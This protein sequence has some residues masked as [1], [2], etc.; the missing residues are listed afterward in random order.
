MQITINDM[1]ITYDIRG[2]GDPVLL[3]HGWGA[4]IDAMLPIANCIVSCGMQA[5]TLDFPGFGKS[6]PPPVPWG[7]REYADFVKEFIRA[8]NL[9]TVDVVC[10]SFGG[11]VTILLAGE[12]PALFRRLV[13]VDAAG[14]R[15]KRSLKYYI[16]TYTYKIGK[17][18]G[19]IKF[20]DRLFHI[21][22]KQKKAGSEEYRALSGV[23]RSTFVKVVNLDLTDK[24]AKI[25]HPTLLIWGSEDQD[26]PLYMAKTMER[27]IPNA[28]LVVFEGA[29]HFSYADE[30]ARFCAVLKSFFGN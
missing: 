9:P 3:L 7:V 21:T 20:L 5:I 11:R 6:D 14:I 23:M 19:K 18:L 4:C 17:R 13:L 16:R 27:L 28:G 8:L 26:T 25:P 29:G 22:E 30:Y 12:D 24:L 2:Q 10:H 15:P 1:Q